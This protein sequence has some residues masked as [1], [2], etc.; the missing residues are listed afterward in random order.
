MTATTGHSK[1]LLR[2]AAA[3]LAGFV[4]VVVLSLGTDQLFHALGMFPPPGQPMHETGLL[5]LAFVYRTVYGI[6]GAYVVA[7]LAPYA[8]MGHALVSGAAGLV[9][10]TTGAVA[11]WHLGSHWYPVALA[12]TALPNSWIGG[13]LYQ[14]LNRTRSKLGR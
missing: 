8:P 14:A 13:L 7:R 10:G 1:H 11:M 12:I 2:S 6:F 4:A 3:L 9:L 5:L